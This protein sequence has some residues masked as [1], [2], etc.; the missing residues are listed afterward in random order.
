MFELLVGRIFSK[1][2]DAASTADSTISGTGTLVPPPESW[3]AP[4]GAS[5][6]TWNNVMKNKDNIDYCTSQFHY[7]TTRYGEGQ[8]VL[9]GCPVSFQADFL[10]NRF[11]TLARSVLTHCKP[12]CMSGVFADHF[13]RLFMPLCIEQN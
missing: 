13:P 3:V 7:L 4:L 1:L 5:S 8:I 9:P 10:S 11:V 6:R 2:D 12:A